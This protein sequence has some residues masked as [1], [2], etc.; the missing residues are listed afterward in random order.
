VRGI[1]GAFGVNAELALRLIHLFRFAWLCRL[2]ETRDLSDFTPKSTVVISQFDTALK[3]VQR[4]DENALMLVFS[5]LKQ[6][7]QSQADLQLFRE[8]YPDIRVR[9]SAFVLSLPVPLF[10]V[11]VASDSEEHRLTFLSKYYM[12]N[13]YFIYYI[14]VLYNNTRYKEK[15]H[16]LDAKYHG[17][18][19]T[20]LH[21]LLERIV[22]VKTKIAKG[23]NIKYEK[24]LPLNASPR[25]MRQLLEKALEH[26]DGGYVE[27]CGWLFNEI[28]KNDLVGNIRGTHTMTKVQSAV[29]RH[30]TYQ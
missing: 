26:P 7:M 11:F 12:G 16:E 13:Y 30:Q 23:G 24:I 19:S 25:K 29:E 9:I 5:T 2:E 18:L 8:K 14:K 4:Q 22:Y 1:A 28:A 20:G 15:I 27:K 6:T 17:Q 3:E 21:S 10:E